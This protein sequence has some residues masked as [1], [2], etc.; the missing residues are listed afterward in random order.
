GRRPGRGVFAQKAA[1]SMVE[2]E[3]PGAANAAVALGDAARLTL[4]ASHVHDNPGSALVVRDGASPR[5]NHNLFARNGL[6][7]RVGSALVLERGAQP[8]FF[9]N[10]FQGISADAFRILGDGAAARVAHDNWFA[11]GPA[12]QGRPSSVPAGRRSR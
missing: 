12:F 10:V 8:T 9:G 7:E 11:D 6:S 2:V 1:G 4:L 5:V 3:T